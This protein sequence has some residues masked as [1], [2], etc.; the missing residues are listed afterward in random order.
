MRNS[1]DLLDLYESYS[2]DV[3]RYLLFLLRNKEVAEDL[4]HDTFLKVH[5]SLH[6]FNQQSSLRTW[7]LKIAGN[8]A[9][10]Y[11]R[12][13]KRV[14]FLAFGKRS[15][16]ITIKTPEL[17][18]IQKADVR[19]LYKALGELKKDYQEV[20]ILRKIQELSIRET[21]EILGWS[22]DKV[23]AKSARALSKLRETFLKEEGTK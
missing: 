16:P 6:Q 12:R 17:N 19:L 10:D 22:E 13:T 9:I 11:I 21:S 15:E 8:T 23:K 18:A 1:I 14:H 3:Y 4:T 5:S 7:L 20:L 2:D